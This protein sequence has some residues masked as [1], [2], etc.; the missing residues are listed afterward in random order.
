MD[1]A[2]EEGDSVSAATESS[3][4]VSGTV[5][6]TMVCEGQIPMDGGGEE[7]PSNGDDIMLEVL[8]SHVYVDGIC[9]TDGGD[10]GIIG[11]GSNDEVVYGHG[12]SGEVGMEGNLRN[13]DSEGDKAA[14][15]GSRSEV[16][17]CEAGTDN[18]L[19]GAEAE[20][21]EKMEHTNGTDEGGGDANQTLEAQKVDDSDGNDLNHGK[22]KAVEFSSV[23]SKGSTVQTEVVE[24]A[25]M[26]IGGDNLNTLDGSCEAIS[27]T[28]KEA[29]DVGVDAKSSDVKTEITVEDVPHSGAK[30]A[31]YSCQSTELVVE[32]GLDET[33]NANL[34]TNKQGADSEQRHMEVDIPYDSSENHAGNGRSLKA[35]TVID[36][37]EEVDLSIGA[38]MDAEKQVSDSKNVG[39]DADRDINHEAS[40]ADNN[41]LNQVHSSHSLG[42]ENTLA[43][44]AASKD[45]SCVAQEM[46][47]EEQVTSDEH[48][49]LDQLKEMEVEE[50]DSDPEQPTDFDEKS[51]K[52]MFLR[53]AS[54]I[55]VHQARYQLQLE[56][57]GE[58]SVSDLIWGKVRSHSW[59]PGQIID[60]SDASEMAFK[61]HKKDTFLVAYFGDRTFSWNEASVLKPFRPHFSQIEK[62]SNSE[63]FHN[64]V[65]CALEEVSR[66][67]ELGLACSC[68]HQDVY[69]RIKFQKI[70]NTGVQQESS[71]RDVVDKSLSAS[72]FKPDKLVDYMK[73]L[74][75]SPAAGGDR[76]DL[77]IAK[78]QLLAFYRLKGY[79]QLPEF[80]SCGDLIENETNTLHSEEKMHFGE[81]IE[82]C[83]PMDTDGEQ[84]FSGQEALKTKRNYYLKRKHN[85]KDGL[86]PSKK[87]RSLTELMGETFGKKRKAVDSFEETMQ[88]GKKTISLAKVSQTASHFPR[89]SFKIGECIRRAAS[90]MTGSPSILKSSGDRFQKFDGGSEYP[91]ADGIDVPVE[92]FEDALQKMM[93]FM[94]DYSS[95]EELLS[96]LHEAACD[97]MKSSFSLIVNFFSNFRDSIVVDQHPGEK[98]SEKRKKSPNSI[99]GSSETFEFDDMNDTYWTDRIVQNGSEEQP[100]HGNGMGQYQLVPVQLEKPLQKGRK[101][102]K[103]YSDGIHDLTTQKPPGYVDERAPA[104]LVMNFTE[105]NSVPSETKLNKMFKHFGPLKESETEV[106]RETSRARVVFRRT[107]DAEVAYNSAGK[108]NIFGPVA[109]NY[110]LNYTIAESFKASLYAP[111]LAQDNPLM[112]SSLCADRALVVSTLGEE[113]S[114]FPPSLGEEASFMV[115]T[116]DEETLPIVTTF[117]EELHSSFGE[118]SLAIQTTICNQ[119]SGVATSIMYEETLPIAT[120]MYEGAMDVASTIGD[121]NFMVATTVGEQF[122]TVVTTISE[123]TSAV[124]S[125]FEEAYPF[126]TIVSKETS[127]ITTNLSEETSTVNVSLGGENSGFVTGGQ[128][129]STIPTTFGEETHTNP[130]TLAEEIHTTPRTSGEETLAISLAEE[131]L[132]VP[133]T[134]GEE[135]PA[136]CVAEETLSISTTLGEETPAIPLAEATPSIPRTLGEDTPTVPLA[137][138]TL[139]IHRTLDEETP[140]IILTEEI[141]SIPR[142]EGTPAISLA[143]ETPNIPRTLGEETSAI[144]ETSSGET[145][146]IPPTSNG[147]T[148]TITPASSG[149]TPTIPPTSSRETPTV[150]IPLGSTTQTTPTVV[151][152][153][154]AIP[155][156]LDKDIATVPATSHEETPAIPTT[157]AEENPTTTKLDEETPTNPTTLGDETAVSLT[158]LDEESSIIPMT[159]PEGTS[160]IPT[161]LSEEASTVLTTNAEETS[162]VSTTTEMETSPPKVAGSKDHST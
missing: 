40:K 102:Q 65:D 124:V 114:H 96:Q 94:A 120:S 22:Q 50:H 98:V 3:L 46:N 162:T 150:P 35:V 41:V 85:L 44:N 29:T 37:A 154:M 16:S 57:E 100:P 27:D 12:G 54:T 69:D 38:A 148:S 108:F 68:I 92:N 103:R 13:L 33:D 161:T 30:D 136:I 2:K 26:T 117:H 82:P 74:A 78:S 49:G 76:L 14:D 137:K 31:V 43:E 142:S 91:A 86:Y 25:A 5:V 10:G 80:Q 84:I 139:S 72:S 18:K 79:H 58:L 101:S 1:E 64:A 52:R 119:T 151:E 7:G 75:E 71:I 4:T 111:T 105:I 127:T 9:T 61:Y 87:E 95:L 83:T 110:Q 47:V 132:S 70:E 128:E 6:E 121:Q 113:T 149:E 104:E 112:S 135:T 156:T 140:A 45:D 147:E 66:R 24:E 34:E 32:C 157:S 144:P 20:D 89:P 123:R 107:S 36:G 67:T 146:T 152:E 28:K 8:G 131:T 59:W 60:T 153:T 62:Q 90:Q 138:E 63:P 73:V 122:S 11:T 48:D 51:V 21:G 88:D 97:P 19:S 42:N 106:D 56:E 129:T 126:S 17:V 116:F 155:E 109:V 118:G 115:S 99:F 125:T 130:V 159:L 81:V 143:E 53:S 55:K 15:L 23:A 93:S 77:V 133:I 158:N 141:P 134:L 39:F 145:P 160:T